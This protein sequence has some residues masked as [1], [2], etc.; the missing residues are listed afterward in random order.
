VL[1]YT[2]APSSVR[3][4]GDDDGSGSS[5]SESKQRVVHV[6]DHSGWGNYGISQE[7]EPVSA[8]SHCACVLIGNRMLAL[9]L[10]PSPPRANGF[11]R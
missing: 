9:R 4:A 11:L 3:P 1:W 5:G 6:S 2:F 10:R 8:C 7:V